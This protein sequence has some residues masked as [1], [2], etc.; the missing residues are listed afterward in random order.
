[1]FRRHDC[2]AHLEIA[3]SWAV[4]ECCGFVLDR[5]GPVEDCHE[6]ELTCLPEE[7]NGTGRA[8]RHRGGCVIENQAWRF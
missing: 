7:R 8:I 2:D 3:E 5:R 4:R 6:K 1:M